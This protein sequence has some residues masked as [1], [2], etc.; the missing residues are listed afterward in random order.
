MLSLESNVESGK[1]SAIFRFKSKEADRHYS[2]ILF[3][4][5]LS[6]NSGC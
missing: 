1:C 6:P 2:V 4:K 5:G 3:Y